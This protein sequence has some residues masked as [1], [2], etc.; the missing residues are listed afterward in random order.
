M[1]KECKNCPEYSRCRDS[2]VSW[3]F[4]VIGLLA[5]LAIR[6]VTVLMHMNEIYGKV[7]WYVGV[8]GFLLFFL[9]KFNIN[10]QRAGIISEKKLLQKVKNQQQLA[11]EDY[12]LIGAI[13]CDLSSN[14]ERIN[15]FFIFGL[16]AVVL[17]VAIYFDVF[18]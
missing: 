3:F 18:K 6:V 13:L 17:V 5:T 16:S 4:F 10:R 8:V 7:A 15:Y 1:K 12:N 2:R 9:Y 14:K 11:G